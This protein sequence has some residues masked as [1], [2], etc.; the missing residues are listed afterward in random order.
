[1]NS[2]III[3]SLT[4]A[5]LAFMHTL[6]GPDHYLPFIVLAKARKWS[7]IKTIWITILCGLGHIGSSVLIGFIGITL[8]IAVSK[9]N[10]FESIRGNIAGW[11]FISFGLLYTIW[12]LRQAY[13]KKPHTHAHL[14]MNGKKHQHEHNHFDEHSHIHTNETIDDE[15][16]AKTSYK[17]LTPWVLFVIFVLGPCEPLIPLIMLPALQHSTLGVI[18][19]TS[20]F[21]IVTILTMTSIVMLMSTGLKFIKLEKME[22]FN[23]AFAGSTILLSGLAIQVLGL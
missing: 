1:M 10:Y 8:G 5:S 14:H 18:S 4:S 6:F 21:G 12:G 13:K 9:L 2:Q 19:V 23:H 17:N 3:L 22:R 7:N 16:S 20:V 15:S 11:L